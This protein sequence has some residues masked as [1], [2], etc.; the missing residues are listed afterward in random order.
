M[1]CLDSKSPENLE[2]RLQRRNVFSVTF[3]YSATFVKLDNGRRRIECDQ[4]RG[5][6]FNMSEGGLGF[7]TDM[8]LKP[9]QSIILF[10]ECIRKTPANATVC[11]TTKISRSLYRT[12]ICFN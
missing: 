3:D 12:G 9:G 5:I 2:K 6:S 10:H 8:E 1:Q 4:S 7:F 11:W